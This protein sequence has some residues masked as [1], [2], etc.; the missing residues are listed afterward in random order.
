MDLDELDKFI[1]WE[2]ARLIKHFYGKST[3]KTK[4]TIFAKVIEEVG[5][6]SECILT[7]EQLQRKEKL[8]K[9]QDKLEHEF[10]DV[11]LSTMILA[12]E[13]NVDLKK[14]LKEKINEIK[15]RNY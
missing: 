13:M 9:I 14:A 1:D 11:I 6:L 15:K 8:D 3:S 4:Y 12:K 5:E 7:S 2:H 10:A